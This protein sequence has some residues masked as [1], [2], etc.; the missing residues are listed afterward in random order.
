MMEDNM[1]T[2]LVR[3]GVAVPL[4]LQIEK[5]FKD[6][7]SLQ[8][9]KWVLDAAFTADAIE[10]NAFVDGMILLFSKVYWDESKK[11]IDD[12]I[13]SNSLMFHRGKSF[14]DIG[15]EEVERIYSQFDE[16]YSALG[17]NTIE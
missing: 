9:Q 6:K 10:S 3:S 4:E 8:N 14:S 11:Q 16:L 5:L 1:R 12:F 13:E 17:G 7:L 15:Y 2:A